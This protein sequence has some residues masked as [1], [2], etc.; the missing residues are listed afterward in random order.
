MLRYVT[1][2]KFAQES[3]YTEEAVRAKIKAGVWLMDLV[4][5]KAPDGRVLIDI[6]GYAKWVEGKTMSE[7]L[8]MTAARPRSIR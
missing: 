2:S 1:I 7:I 6:E 3:G 8:T 5:K 4:W